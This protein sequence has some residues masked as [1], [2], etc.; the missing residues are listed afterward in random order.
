MG[1]RTVGERLGKKRGGGKRRA[2]KWSY[3]ATQAEPCT[4]EFAEREGRKLTEAALRPKERPQEEAATAH[5]DH[6]ERPLFSNFFS[7]QEEELASESTTDETAAP[8]QVEELPPG[9]LEE[10][11][12]RILEEQEL[13]EAKAAN[14]PVAATFEPKR[15]KLLHYGRPEREDCSRTRPSKR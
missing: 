9:A 14:E 7:L 15:R 5:N 11:L 12:T 6:S 1:R 3:V 10:C 2:A 4:K 13:L 8:L